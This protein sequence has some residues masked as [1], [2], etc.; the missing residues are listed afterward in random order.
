MTPIRLPMHLLATLVAGI[1]LAP[2]TLAE[3]PAD[4]GK[5]AAQAPDKSKNKGAET[6][7]DRYHQDG[8]D[9]G[10]GNHGQVVS[11][12]NHR[13][14]EKSLKGKDRREYVEW[15]TDR[16]EHYKYDDRRYDQD[17][18]C[19]KRADEKGLGGDFRRVFIQDCLRKQEK[20]R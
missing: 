3:P 12:C 7:P 19:Y 20:N 13:A 14:T 9:N 1:L 8:K 4:K 16:G 15:C 11:E 5:S 17:R 10:E 6:A 18:S 2:V